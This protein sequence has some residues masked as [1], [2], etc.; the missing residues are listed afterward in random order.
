MSSEEEQTLSIAGKLFRFS[1]SGDA[2]DAMYANA[3]YLCSIHVL[4]CKKQSK[5]VC[6][7]QMLGCRKKDA[8]INAEEEYFAIQGYEPQSLVVLLQVACIDRL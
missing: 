3:V 1:S 6:I 7:M 4:R 2:G 5:H 8:C